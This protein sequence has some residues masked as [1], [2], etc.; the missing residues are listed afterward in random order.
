MKEMKVGIEDRQYP[1]L[2]K[3]ML[4]AP[5]QLY[6][7]GNVDVLG[8]P[9][10]AVV[11]SRR[12]SRKG[13]ENTKLVVEGLVGQG[14]VIVSGLA[15]G[16]DTIAHQTALECGGKTIA[17]LAHG[18]D[19][20]YPKEN[21]TLAEEIVRSG[22]ALISE[23]PVAVLPDPKYFLE[24]NRIIV[25]MSRGLVVVEAQLRS[26]SL[27]SA[28]TAAEMGRTVIAIPG[29]PGTDLLIADGC[30]VIEMI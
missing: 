28:N 4:G 2:L 8:L 20:V 1:S 5:R 13:G 30:E 6:V 11:G 15:K 10:M 7:R 3:E 16:V 17:V 14:Y 26:G 9:M 27:A 12:M 29:S 25:G 19:M 22:G 18:L 21:E 24:R 23:L